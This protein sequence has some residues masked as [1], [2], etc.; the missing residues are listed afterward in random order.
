MR[1]VY[2]VGALL[3]VGAATAAPRSADPVGAAWREDLRVIERELP[4]IHPNAFARLP[5]ATWDSALRALD[6]R[7][8]GLSRTQAQVGLMELVALVRDG[9][10]S[11]NPLFDPGFGWHYYPVRFEWFADGLFVR[12]ADSAYATMTGGRVLRI[13]K[14]SADAALAAVARTLPTENEWWVRANAPARLSLVELIEGLG[15]AEHADALPVV[16]ERGGRQETFVLRPAGPLTPTGHNPD[17]PIDMHDW[18]DMRVG[19]APLWQQQPDRPYWMRYQADARVIYVSYRGV[20]DA[21]P[22]TNQQF[23]RSVFALADSVPVERFVLDLRQNS[24]GNSFLN[25]QVVRGIVARPA[26]DRPDRLFVLIG[27]R[28]FSAAMNLVLDLEQWT[29]AT[30]V[31]EPTGNATNFFGDHRQVS[32]PRSGLVLNVS[33]LPWYSYDPRDTRETKLP[34]LYTPISSEDYRDGR[35][36][37]L[38]MLDPARRT[39]VAEVVAPLVARNDTAA[40]LVELTRLRDRPLNR[41]RS[42]EAEV[43]AMG[44]ALLREG[45]APA[46]LAVL[47]ANTQLYP[48]SANTWDS[49]GETLAATG[50]PDAAITAY[51][52]AL[53]LD[54]T[55][56]SSRQALERL[57][58][59]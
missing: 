15:L 3:F 59:R 34:S 36:P 11:L 51:R 16:L 18:T 50:Q 58:A 6:R 46:A 7:L 48:A 52:K 17:G 33:T 9:H 30:F 1:P 24:G 20:V 10:T 49:L 25:R 53:A 55:F 31:G 12:S 32:L 42:L 22:P 19:E 23:W 26:L 44:Y 39:T 38:T 35:D 40:I 47:R 43:N 56:A 21:P 28:T 8:P 29:N 14:V 57:G 54:S 5:R 45:K 2:L 4:R 37:A 41:F 13:G 27:G